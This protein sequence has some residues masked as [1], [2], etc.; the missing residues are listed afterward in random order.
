MKMRKTNPTIKEVLE[1]LKKLKNDR[2]GL[3]KAVKKGLLRPRRRKVEV[4][5]SHISRIVK[6]EGSLV[7]VPGKVLGAGILERKLSIAAY[8]FSETAKKKIEESGGSALELTSLLEDRAL[9]KNYT[10]IG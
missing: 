10:I 6:D 4:N 2:P 7:I 1:G 9:P 3:Y 8:A 5:L